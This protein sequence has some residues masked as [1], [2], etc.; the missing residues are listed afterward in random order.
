MPNVFL[1]ENRSFQKQFGRFLTK[2][3]EN[4]FFTRSGCVGEWEDGLGRARVT[5]EKGA[6]RLLVQQSRGN[7]WRDAAPVPLTLKVQDLNGKNP[8]DKT[9][10]LQKNLKNK[11]LLK[12][13]KGKFF[14][15]FVKK[16][17]IKIIKFFGGRRQAR[18]EPDH[19]GRG[20][21]M[22]GG[23][24]EEQKKRSSLSARAVGE[25]FTNFAPFRR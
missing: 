8:T 18:N 20:A 11:P 23:V 16:W 21:R 13:F 9:N 12:L 4:S 19:F 24:G 1:I 17:P 6:R 14:D 25:I 2:I 22:G 5:D 10:P 3:L 7:C 15:K